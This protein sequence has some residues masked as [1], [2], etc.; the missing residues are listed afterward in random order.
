MGGPGQTHISAKAR[1]AIILIPIFHVPYHSSPTVD[2]LCIIAALESSP[3]SG[4][5]SDVT[6][7]GDQLQPVSISGSPNSAAG[8]QPAK[9]S[10]PSNKVS[11]TSRTHKASS[12]EAMAAADDNATTP[13][14]DTAAAATASASKPKRV[15]TGCLTCR[16]RHLK[17]DEGLPHCQNC[18]KSSRTCKR[19]VRLNFIDTQVKDPQIIP[20]TAD[21][22]VGFQDESREIASEYKGGAGRYAALK[23]EVVPEEVKNETQMDT[24]GGLLNAPMMSHQQLPPIHSFPQDP[25]TVYSETSSSMHESTRD[26]H[27]RQHSYAESTSSHPSMHAPS[28]ASFTSSDQTLQTQDETRDY[29]TSPE[30]TLFMQVFV[31]EVGLWM[32]SMDPHKHV[33]TAW[34]RC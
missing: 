34:P 2:R 16:E 17:C 33:S 11:K 14:N 18:R 28:Q 29:L 7:L 31:E 23:P 15:R 30:E 13:P 21:W 10:K 25:N 3:Y 20:P 9:T 8:S 12:A 6:L 19:G 22:S 5:V 4:A 27:R 24:S 32:D 26:G 1:L